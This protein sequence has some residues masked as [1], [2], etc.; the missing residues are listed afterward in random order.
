MYL[1]IIIL[2]IFII[3]I[4][5]QFGLRKPNI[6]VKNSRLRLAASEIDGLN[7]FSIGYNIKDISKMNSLDV[8]LNGFERKDVSDLNYLI[9]SDLWIPEK[10]NTNI[11]IYVPS[12]FLT[13]V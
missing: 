12:N 4:Y 13:P 3:M 5:I 10:K 8:S 11:T 1:T 6:S 2:Q 9:Y 7:H